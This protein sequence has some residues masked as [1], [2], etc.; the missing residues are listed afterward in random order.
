MR[1]DVEGLD[2]HLAMVS[3]KVH[4]FGTSRQGFVIRAKVMHAAARVHEPRSIAPR[5]GPAIVHNQGRN[6]LSH[7][8]LALIALSFNEPQLCRQRW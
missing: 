5:D 6:S 8:C 2:K 1:A 4:R 3:D 7:C